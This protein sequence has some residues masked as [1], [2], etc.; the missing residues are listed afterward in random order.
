MYVS[1]R[2]VQIGK[3]ML[4]KVAGGSVTIGAA[5]PPVAL[6]EV[7]TAWKTI[8]K[9]NPAAADAAT[10]QDGRRSLTQSDQQESGPEET[11]LRNVKSGR[12]DL[13][14]RPLGPERPILSKNGLFYRVR[15]LTGNLFRAGCPSKGFQEGFPKNRLRNFPKTG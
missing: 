3:R 9:T 8:K 7:P 6:Y 4:N 15:R 1:F 10:G 13:N 2:S 11:S 5:P 12:Q 14:L